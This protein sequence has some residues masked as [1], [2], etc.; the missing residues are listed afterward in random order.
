MAC[1][2]FWHLFIKTVALSYPT[3]VPFEAYD[4]GAIENSESLRVKLDSS[5]DHVIFLLKQRK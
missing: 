3:K 1:E 5:S 4:E 2:A